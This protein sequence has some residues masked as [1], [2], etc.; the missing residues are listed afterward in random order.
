MN[1]KRYIILAIV[2]AAVLAVG[3]AAVILP[4]HRQAPTEPVLQTDPTP[5]GVPAEHTEPSAAT[6]V[7]TQPT[8]PEPTQPTEPQPQPQHFTLTFAGDCTLGTEEGW[9][10]DKW[11]FIFTVGQDYD[12]PFRNVAEFFRGDDCTF[13]NLESVLAEA[14]VGKAQDKRFRFRGPVTYTQILIGSSVEAVSLANNHSFDYGQ[15]GYDSTKAALEGAGVAYAETDSSVLI[16]TE[17][18]LTVGMYAINFFMNLEDMKREIA[19]MRSNGAE[20][21]VLSIHCGDE[22]VY[23]PTDKQV[24]YAHQAIDAGV[25]IVW[26]HHPHVLQ[27]IEEYNGGIIFYSLGNFSFG[28]NHNPRDKDTAVVQQEIIRDTDGTVRLGTLT[29]IPCRISSVSDRNDFQPTPYEAGSEEYERTLRKLNRTFSGP[30]LIPGDQN[31]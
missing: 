28:G 15:P 17:R 7:P 12:Y 14:G 5:S 10:N 26:G 22:G 2:L 21:I 11:N 9:W 13:V 8:E 3:A 23:T 31:P 6:T 16:T 24:S 18:G 20:I 4:E 30:D 1:R 25:D 29:V 27:R 19:E